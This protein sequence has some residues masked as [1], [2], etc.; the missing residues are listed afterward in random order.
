MSETPEGAVE[1]DCIIT[2]NE[3]KKTE[4]QCIECGQ[5]VEARKRPSS[6]PNC[7]CVDGDFGAGVRVMAPRDVVGWFD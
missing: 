3:P 4:Y 1:R 6:C 7:N 5:V 2:V